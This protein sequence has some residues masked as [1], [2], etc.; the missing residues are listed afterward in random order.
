M[1]ILDILTLVFIAVL[2][3]TGAGFVLISSMS[4]HKAKDAYSRINSL[5]PG[6]GFGMP[7]LVGA[8]F[9]HHTWLHAFEWS[10]FITAALAILA[11]IIVSSIASNTLSR[12][13][14]LSGAPVDPR[15]TPQEL[16]EEPVRD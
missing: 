7:L 6:T 4:M 14:Y 15:T 1:S 3:L 13:A 8:A 9:V 11:L 12:A 16:A 2:I 10:A 5:S